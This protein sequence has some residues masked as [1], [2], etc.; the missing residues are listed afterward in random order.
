[1]ADAIESDHS[2]ARIAVVFQGQASD[3]KAWSGIPAGISA[4]LRANGAEAVA[5]DARMPA[6]AWVARALRLDWIG[7]TT[8]PLF[9]AAGGRRADAAIRR[10][11]EIDAAVVIGSGFSLGA[12]VPTATYE[13][14]TVAQ[15]LRQPGSEYEGLGAR[16]ARR[17]RERQRRNYERARA[18]CVAS[19]WAAE[20][21]R[22]D[23]GIAAEKVH[24]IGF[25]RNSEPQRVQ[26]DWSVPHFLFLGIDWERKQGQAVLDAFAAIRA[27]HPQATLDLVGGHPPVEAPGVS[28]HGILSLD[29]AA[30]RKRQAQILARATC[31][32]LPSKFE[33]FGIA[34]VDAGAS[35]VASIGTTSG[36]AATAIGDGGFL[37]DPGDMQGLRQAML[38]MCDPETAREL[39]ERAFAHAAGLSWQKVAQRMHSI[40]RLDRAAG[41]P[42]SQ[43]HS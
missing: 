10:A 15:A 41:H 8:N 23:Y 36:G 7:Q 13:D 6:A 43:E 19:E 34:Y 24:V 16:G 2:P 9:A 20:S 28:G 33:P 21:V 25:G 18:C 30:D 29:S 38:K 31:L 3:P 12:A 40:L 17:W 26:R 39:G 1:M 11:G 5:V 37:V 4:G 14:M 42:Y 22:E 35:G 27:S 32:V